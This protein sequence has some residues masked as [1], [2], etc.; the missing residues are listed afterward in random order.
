MLADLVRLISRRPTADYE[1]GFVRS[2]SVRQRSPRN[3]RVE[4]VIAV[5][6]A[7]IALKSLAVVWL[8]G[9]YNVPVSPLW[10]IAPTVFFAALCTA[11]YLLRD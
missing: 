5:C 9:R 2:V 7:I 10:V 3:P 8:F 6:W 4:R 11:V 1:R